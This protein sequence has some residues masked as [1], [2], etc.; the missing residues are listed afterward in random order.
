MYLPF[1]S[2]ATIVVIVVCFYLSPSAYLGILPRI[3]H[4]L[5][6]EVVL[7]SPDVL[8]KLLHIHISSISPD[9][10]YYIFYFINHFTY[11]TLKTLIPLLLIQ[12][13]FTIYLQR[14][15]IIRQGKHKAF[16]IFIT[17]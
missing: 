3:L 11:N 14:P 16:S 17:I 10:P 8:L 2:Y 12:L 1:E 15:T 6:L 7:A 13:F 9:I 4:F 5:V